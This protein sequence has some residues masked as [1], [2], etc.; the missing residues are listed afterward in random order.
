[1]RRPGRRGIAAVTLVTALTVALGV[2]AATAAPAPPSWDDVEQARGDVQATQ[3]A[4]ARIEDAARA[5]EQTYLE[6]ARSAVLLGEEYHLAELALEQ[7]EAAAGRLEQ[8][9]D[10]ALDRAA[11]SG[12]RAAQLA[13][14]LA[15]SGSGDLTTALLTGDADDADDLLYR[16]GAMSS[17]GARSQAVMARA[18]QDKNTAEALTAQAEL[19]LAERGRLAD[20]ASDSLAAAI[21]AAEQAEQRLA[22]QQIMM[23]ELAAQLASLTGRSEQLEREYL[24]G[25]GGDEEPAPGN[26]APGTPSSPAPS[27]SSPPPAPGPSPSI[28]PPSPSPSP[29][30]PPAP[31]PPSVPAPHAGAV[32]TAISFAR[33][34]VGEPYQFGGRGPDVW[35]CSGLTMQAYAAAGVSIG[36]HSATRQYSTAASRNRL[37]PYAQAQA[38]DLIFYSTGGAT[39]GSKYHVTLY[40]GGGQMIEAPYPGKTVR[41]VAVRSYDRVPYVARPTP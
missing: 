15:R 26:Q 21:A 23:G 32:A 27:P 14:Q 19:A 3:L 12:A 5:A 31:N 7:A 9:R 22:T 24:A 4:I 6:A 35:D 13:A 34:Q 8:R 39:S 25:L 38:G 30:T 2:T 40:I 10:A 17:V 29:S 16:L 33:A 36:G 11:E 41:I 1:M 20:E 28:P 18:M 37:V